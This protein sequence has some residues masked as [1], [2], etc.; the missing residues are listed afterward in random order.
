M[1]E[2]I[3]LKGALGIN[4]RL[5]PIRHQYNPDTGVGFLSEA[6]NCDIDDSGMIS[7]RLGQEEI[8][9]NSFI[10][11]F[12]DKGDCFVVQN[13]D[14]DSAIMQVGTD[15]S[16]TGV[17]SGLTLGAKMAFCQVGK[18]TYYSNGFQNGVIE[19]GISDFWPSE[20]HFGAETERKFYSAP[21]GTHLTYFDGRMLVAKDNVIWISERYEVGKFRMKKNL[22]QMGTNITM[23]KA[24][25]GGLWV[26]D[27]EKTG[28]VPIKGGDIA[29]A[30]FIKKA[31]AS[32]HEWSECIELIDLSKS[33]LQVSGLSAVWSSDEGLCVGSED[34]QI[35]I[36]TE[37][38]LIYS[39]GACGATV[40]DGI[41]II[42]NVY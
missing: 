37:N 35:H 39:S 4:N 21:L 15:F 26:S 25:L 30:P 38:N 13:R 29:Q 11:A 3:I 6:V 20:E 22:F 24:V 33:S 16:L 41:N 17:R 8:S 31:S 23:I 34:G 28:F 40:A 19:N 5:D 9:S 18:K 1:T 14:T 7:R 10:T 27:Q 42:N 2:A 12:C 36:V 32:A